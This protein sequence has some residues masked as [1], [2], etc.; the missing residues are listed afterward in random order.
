MR[1]AAVPAQL[2][3]QRRPHHVT[4]IPDGL[5]V[6]RWGRITGTPLIL[7]VAAKKGTV[8]GYPRRAPQAARSLAFA[9]AVGS[10]ADGCGAEGLAA[11]QGPEEGPGSPETSKQKVLHPGNWAVATVEGDA[12]APA[13]ACGAAGVVGGPLVLTAD[14][15][16]FLRGGWEAAAAAAE[17]V[18][19]SAERS[20]AEA[21]PKTSIKAV[22]K[23]GSWAGT[24]NLL[25]AT[26][27]GVCSIQ[28]LDDPCALAIVV[29]LSRAA[30]ASCLL[31]CQLL[32]GP[33]AYGAGPP[34]QAPGGKLRKQSGVIRRMR[35]FLDR[36]SRRFRAA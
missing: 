32:R 6:D 18:E 23:D 9:P 4:C 26:V 11:E 22:L 31:G 13:T 29:R 20:A 5:Q 35:G 16:V 24:V 14:P 27:S 10:Q 2:L 34:A 1:V 21:T 3:D 28:P 8:A 19:A 30:G 12:A 36:Q 17:P 33:C 15:A 25:H 7:P